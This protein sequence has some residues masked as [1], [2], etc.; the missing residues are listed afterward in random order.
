MNACQQMGTYQS[1]ADLGSDTRLIMTFNEFETDSQKRVGWAITRR[2]C[3]HCTNAGCVTVCPAGALYHDE[4]TGLVTHDQSKCIGCQRCSM[5]CPFDVPRYCDINGKTVINKCSGCIDRVKN[6]MKPACVTTCQPNALDFGDRQEMIKKAKEAVERLQALGYKDACVYGEEEMDGLHV[7]QVLKYGVEKAGQIKNPELPASV[8]LT[9]IMKPVAAV[10]M[11]ATVL[12]L[13]AMA[14]LAHGYKRD[15]VVYNEATG[16]TISLETGDV[17]K[18]GDPQDERSVSEAL[19]ENLPIKLP[20][21][22]KKAE[23]NKAKR[24]AEAKTA[25]EGKEAGDE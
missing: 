13:G 22:S 25:E 6:G 21:F 10:G 19:T 11:G 18:K 23:E 5:A 24:A 15:T 20:I 3:Q 7:I 9:E 17:V 12:G 16:D 14:A 8:V 4:E 1:P 2:A